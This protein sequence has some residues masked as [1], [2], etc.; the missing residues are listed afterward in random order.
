MMS[1]EL[2]CEAAFMLTMS[3]YSDVVAQMTI[4]LTWLATEWPRLL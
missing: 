1:S 2:P 3:S 4:T